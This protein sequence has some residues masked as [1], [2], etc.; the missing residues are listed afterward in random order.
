MGK[1]KFEEK[2]YDECVK[3][4][5]EAIMLSETKDCMLFTDIYDCISNIFDH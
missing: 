2:E 3:H 5:K 1:I 4:F